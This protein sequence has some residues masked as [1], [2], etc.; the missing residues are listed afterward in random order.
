MATEPAAA[1]PKV[2]VKI[3]A[4]NFKFDKE[5]YRYKKGDTLA[6]T[7]ENK[8]GMHG[9]EIRGLNVSVKPGETKTV[10]LNKTGS[11]DILCNIMCGS[12]HSVMK[13]K[14]IVE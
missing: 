12:G 7:I 3:V 14:L 11:F 5:E 8:E 13:S 1:G 2:D 4:S 6:I 9:I 10:T